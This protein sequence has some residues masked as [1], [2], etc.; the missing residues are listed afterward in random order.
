MN[1]KDS[2]QCKHKQN[3]GVRLRILWVNHEEIPWGKYLNSVGKSKN[4]LTYCLISYVS[5][6]E[7]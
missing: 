2:K 7:G 1:Y 3:Y 6:I 4:L 5:H